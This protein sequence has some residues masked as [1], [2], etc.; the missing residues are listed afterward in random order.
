MIRS[1]ARCTPPPPFYLRL[2]IYL[3]REAQWCMLGRGS[4]RHDQEFMNR[5]IGESAGGRMFSRFRAGAI[6]TRSTTG[7]LHLSPLFILPTDF[8]TSHRSHVQ[9]R[10][11]EAIPPLRLRSERGSFYFAES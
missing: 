11:N 5:F 4:P 6:L 9:I 1:G 7:Q 10:Q 8:K 2:I 3:F